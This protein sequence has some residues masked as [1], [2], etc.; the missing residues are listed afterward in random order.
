[1]TQ[2]VVLTKEELEQIIEDAVA[3]GVCMASSTLAQDPDELLDARQVAE[4]LGCSIDTWYRRA[5]APGAPPAIGGARNR[6][7]RRGAVVAWVRQQERL[8]MT[9]NRI[10][11]GGQSRRSTK[12]AGSSR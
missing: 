10:P 12:S 9:K 4:L 7:W 2:V 5:S 6:R 8:R 1:M 11:Y 3:K